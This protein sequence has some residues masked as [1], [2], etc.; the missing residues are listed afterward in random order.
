MESKSKILAIPLTKTERKYGYI[1]WRKDKDVQIRE[2]F[3]TGDAVTL[4][5]GGRDQEIKR[6]DLKHRRIGVTYTLTR[7]L[8]PDIQRI[9]LRRKQG[10]V[11]VEFE[12]E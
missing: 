9:K 3:G 8:Q 4:R 10:I 12:K 7:N 5:M 6:I 2:I 1:T 11:I